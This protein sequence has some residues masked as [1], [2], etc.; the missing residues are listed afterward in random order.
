MAYALMVITLAAFALT[1][2]GV[3]ALLGRLPR[4]SWAG[5]RLPVIMASED[6]W[7]RAHRAAGP[8]M[9]F[10]GVAAFAISLAF[11]P[12]ALADKVS[13]GATLIV[14]L[15]CAGIL[16]G[17]A[18]STAIIAVSVAQQAPKPPKTPKVPKA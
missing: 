14:V 11:V 18:F 16:I 3:G 5:I 12:F 15:T 4:N 17:T 2:V 9:I 7:M 1:T 6:A 8:M 10:G 13:D